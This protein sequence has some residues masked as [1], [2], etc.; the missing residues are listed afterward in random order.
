MVG[1]CTIGSPQAP[2]FERAVR[3]R[4]ETAELTGRQVADLRSIEDALEA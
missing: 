3:N 2:C 1:D 4:R